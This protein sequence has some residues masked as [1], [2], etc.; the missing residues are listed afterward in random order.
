MTLQQL[1]SDSLS[2]VKVIGATTGKI[3]KR[4]VTEQTLNSNPKLADLHILGVQSTFTSS[5]DPLTCWVDEHEFH[6]KK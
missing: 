1:V 4:K 6:T 2:P 5:K 3:L